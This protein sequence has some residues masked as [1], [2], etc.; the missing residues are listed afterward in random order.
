MLAWSVNEPGRIK[1]LLSLGIA[2]IITDV[3]EVA[4][5]VREGLT[6]HPEY[7]RQR[8]A[9]IRKQEQDDHL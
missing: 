7:V 3:L 1:E 5:K 9:I 6:N 2:G 8:E 4:I